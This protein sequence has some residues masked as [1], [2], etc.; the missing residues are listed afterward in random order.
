MKSPETWCKK[1]SSIVD[2]SLSELPK[3][4]HILLLQY[5]NK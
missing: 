4:P 2:A 1:V 5:Q 3:R